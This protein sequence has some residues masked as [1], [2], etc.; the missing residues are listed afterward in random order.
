MEL[1]TLW[2]D[3]YPIWND[4]SIPSTNSTYGGF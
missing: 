1:F 3:S 2:I 4:Y